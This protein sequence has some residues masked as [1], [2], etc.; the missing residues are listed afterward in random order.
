MY[1][2]PVVLLL[3]SAAFLSSSRAPRGGSPKHFCYRDNQDGVP[4]V[5]LAAGLGQGL[6]T[7]IRPVLGINRTSTSTV[8]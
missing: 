3:L 5:G 6:P 1:V 4:F 7:A 2:L 8:N